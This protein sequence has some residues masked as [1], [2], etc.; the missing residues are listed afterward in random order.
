MI[1]I[2]TKEQTDL[3]WKLINCRTNLCLRAFFTEARRIRKLVSLFHAI[4]LLLCEVK[5]ASKETLVFAIT[6]QKEAITC[7][8][9]G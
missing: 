3:L 6:H 5:T 9:N 2:Q 1:K 4:E 8:L 7:F